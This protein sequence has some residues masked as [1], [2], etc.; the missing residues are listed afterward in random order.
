M[1]PQSRRQFIQK[2]LGAF[3]LTYAGSRGMGLFSNLGYAAPA[4][5]GAALPAGMSEV[6]AND[7]VASA[8]GYVS[9]ATKVEAKANPTFKKG[10]TCATCALYSKTNDSWG[11]CQMIQNG[12][13]RADGW[14]KSFNK[15]A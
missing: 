7:P 8:I 3:A 1:N 4:A 11:K 10:Q 5:K 15:K 14:C 13:V 6:A 9:D 2:V 12:L